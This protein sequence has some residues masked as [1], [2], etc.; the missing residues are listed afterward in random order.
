MDSNKCPS[1]KCKM[2]YKYV[3]TTCNACEK[4]M[5]TMKCDPNNREIWFKHQLPTG[6]DPVRS[7]IVNGFWMCNLDRDQETNS[8][9]CKRTFFDDDLLAPFIYRNNLNLQFAKSNAPK[10]CLNN[11]KH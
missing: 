2:C 3:N 9:L 4:K 6:L 7:N 8:K 1:G 5:P 10:Y 11:S